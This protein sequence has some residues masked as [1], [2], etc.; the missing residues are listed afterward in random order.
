MS[1]PSFQTARLGIGSHDRP[2]AVVCVMELASMIAGERFSDRPVSV[3]PVIGAILRVYNDGLDDQRRADLYRYAA[4][5]VGTR[6]DFRLQL[7]RAQAAIS[8]AR[9]RYQARGPLARG[10][11]PR[12]VPAPDWGPDQI[13]TYVVGA[14]GRRRRAGGWSATDH[15]EALAL[16]DELI[17]LGY[18]TPDLASDLAPAPPALASGLAP[19][20]AVDPVLASD[21]APAPAVDPAPAFFA[22]LRE[23]LAGE[24]V[25]QVPEP[26]EYG[27]RGA[28]LVV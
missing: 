11:R 1:S 14:L 15:A 7:R 21:L 4:E 6:G 10:P 12:S 26:V 2:G 20:P 8:W 27:C 16:I 18:R 23:R 24:F 25:E 22:A 28:E 3:C 17:E 19:A 5:A 13:A 9:G